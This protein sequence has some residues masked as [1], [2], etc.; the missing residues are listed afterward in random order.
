CG[1]LERHEMSGGR[2]VLQQAR[3]RKVLVAA[4][5]C[6]LGPAFVG[7]GD[8]NLGPGSILLR[9]HVIKI[10]GRGAAGGNKAGAALARDAPHEAPSDLTGECPVRSVRAM[11]ADGPQPPA[12]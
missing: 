7:E 5:R 2:L 6:G 11:A 1:R 3:P 8:R 12:A 9:E 10:T 4:R